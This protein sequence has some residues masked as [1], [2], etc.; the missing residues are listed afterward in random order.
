M[1]TPTEAGTFSVPIKAIDEQGA[2]ARMVYRLVVRPA[3]QVTNELLPDGRDGTPYSTRLTAK[4]GSGIIIWDI[5]GDLPLG[6][7]LQDDRISGT[8][9][10]TG[11]FTLEVT[12]TDGQGAKSSKKLELTIDSR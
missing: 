10:E 4:G 7:R 11:T 8:P 12:A 3:P 6:I 1:G 2:W 9:R 5:A